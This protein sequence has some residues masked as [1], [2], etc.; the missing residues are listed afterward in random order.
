MSVRFRSI[1]YAGLTENAN[2]LLSLVQEYYG[3][4]VLVNDDEMHPAVRIRLVDNLLNNAKTIF[5]CTALVNCFFFFFFN[6]TPDG[7]SV[8]L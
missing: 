8:D 6:L 4:C 7:E 5:G 1:N 2:V 3:R